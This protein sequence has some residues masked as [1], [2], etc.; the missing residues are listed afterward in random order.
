MQ[1]EAFLLLAHEYKELQIPDRAILPGIFAFTSC[2]IFL[3][4]FISYARWV[5]VCEM[6]IRMRDGYSGYE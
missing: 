2:F 4:I 3:L 5:F 1:Q 6:G